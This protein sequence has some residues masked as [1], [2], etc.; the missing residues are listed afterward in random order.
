MLPD[1]KYDEWSQKDHT[2]REYTSDVE[3]K[4]FGDVEHPKAAPQALKELV[5]DYSGFLRQKTC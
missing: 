2:E 3:R 4:F 5:R 1:R